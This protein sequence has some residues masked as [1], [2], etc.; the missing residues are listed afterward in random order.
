MFKP[1]DPY[2]HYLLGRH[3]QAIASWDDAIFYFRMAIL[4]RFDQLGTWQGLYNSYM[5]KFGYKNGIQKFTDFINNE[6]AL[7]CSVSDID[8]VLLIRI[9][10]SQF[11]DG[12]VKEG[13][14][15]FSP[16]ESYRRPKEEG[17]W[18][19]PDEN[20]PNKIVVAE[21][22]ELPGMHIKNSVFTI[23]GLYRILCF[24]CV[25]KY[26]V[27]NFMENY[28]LSKFQNSEG[29]KYSAVVIHRSKELIE[30]IVNKN[31]S[32]DFG[33]VKYLPEGVVQKSKAIYSPFVK[34]E[35]YS[36]EF[37]F[38]FA[39]Q[40]SDSG[41]RIKDAIFLDFGEIEEFITVMPPNELFDYIK[42]W[43]AKNA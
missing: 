36:P 39:T 3:Y 40:K 4:L 6:I 1:R 10:E 31:A 32:I 20:R 26:N 12:F 25:S 19:D 27:K 35:E 21:D 23:G 33:Y 8:D 18:F 22:V 43:R 37:E 13:Q 9:T 30:Q 41:T 29:K 7:P 24:S 14:G 11:V 16:T 28:D 17:P 34:D 42:A 2:L 38:R 15:R 5:G